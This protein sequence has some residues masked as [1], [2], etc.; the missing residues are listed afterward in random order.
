MAHHSQPDALRWREFVVL[1]DLDHAQ[2]TIE[3]RA[4]FV[5]HDSQELALRSAP[6]FGVLEGFCQRQFAALAIGDVSQGADQGARSPI[7][8]AH[9]LG[10]G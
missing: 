7:F 4:G 8:I 1:H 2:D 9:D 10:G 6:G 5:A 3:G